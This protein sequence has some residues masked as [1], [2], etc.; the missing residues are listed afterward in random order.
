M[1]FLNSLRNSGFAFVGQIITILLGFVVRWFF[2]H[3]L[4]REYLG[5]NSVMESMLTILSVTE[6]GIGTSI[7]F[8]LYKPIDNGD[9]KKVAAL[10]SL[11]KKVYHIIGILTAIVGPMLIPFMKF[12][13]REAA[14]VSGL[15]LI[16]ILFLSNTVLSYFFSYKRTLLSAYQQNYIN[17]L[18]EDLFA[19][20]KYLLQ[21]VVL[22]VYRSYIG[23]L[24]INLVCT[25]GANVVISIIC[26][27]KYPLL[28]K[29]KNEKLTK[30]D[31]AGLK[32]SIVSLIYQKVG[33]KLV[34]G[35]DNLMISYAKLSLMGIYSNYA[36]VV[37]TVS[38]V[39]YNVLHSVMG[40][41]GNLMVQ[42]DSEHKNNV[43]EEFAFATFCFYFFI[44]I[45]FAACLERF[46]VIWAGEDWLLSPAVTFIVIMNFFLM[47]MRQP[48]IVVIEAA[49]LFNKMRMK[50]VGEVIVNLVVSFV[51]LIVFEMGIYGVLLG[52]TVSMVSI[53]IWWE[54]MAVHK[55]SLHVSAKK[56][57]SDLLGYI[58]VAA[59][60]CLAAYFVNRI[61]PVDG[62]LG[63]ILSGFAAVVI[64]TLI[65]LT[66]YRRSRRFKAL[67][68]RFIKRGLTNE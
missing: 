6:L 9:D 67:A 30:E 38:R 31:T 61:I 18:S 3:E 35:T 16:Y 28:K 7:A 48:C 46:I 56:Y 58:A 21:I 52:T 53:C 19:V 37:S 59:T 55:Y 2:V 64:F 8:A 43:F 22:L 65:I 62:I 34:T 29:Y 40:S 36:M 4:G 23:Y 24:V 63:L 41:I 11:Y 44:S 50:A 42:K 12:F 47:G 27:R 49:G 32:K 13:T 57:T 68:G 10:M 39:V 1:R 5:V 66:V 51:F 20:L 54:I 26:D 15:T 45:G 14:D 33:A 17:S 60:G 25:L